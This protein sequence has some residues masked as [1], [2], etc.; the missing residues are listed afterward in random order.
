[1]YCDITTISTLWF[2]SF[3]NRFFLSIITS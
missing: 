2:W 1:M 3:F